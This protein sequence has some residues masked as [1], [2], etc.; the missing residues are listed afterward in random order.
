MK[1]RLWAILTA[2]CGVAVLGFFAAFSVLPETKAAALCVTANSLTQFEL[3]HNVYDLRS[4]F[5]LPG[6]A[7]RPLVIAAMDAMNHLN[8]MAFVPAY[9]AFCCSAAAFVSEGKLRPLALAALAAVLIATAGDLMAT[10]TLLEI[11]P[12]LE[13]SDDLLARSVS[14]A[15]TKFAG[16]AL[17]GLAIAAICMTTR[18]RRLLL[19]VL[20]L[21]P[22][23][24]A[25]MMALDRTQFIAGGG[26]GFAVM[27]AGLMAA[28]LKESVMPR[29]GPD[30]KA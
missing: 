12:G 14:G 5:G 30:A 10:R 16:L 17:Y 25:L 28:A 3:A 9:A 2:L 13:N 18:P 23:I 21:G 15:W 8:M 29:R 11:T 4:L 24:G 20:A 27:W 22:A 6:S 19:A 26:L 7:C 1:A